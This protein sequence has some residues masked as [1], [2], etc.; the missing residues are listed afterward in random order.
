MHKISVSYKHCLNFFLM[1]P[2]H[3]HINKIQYSDKRGF[4]KLHV[5]NLDY[6]HDCDLDLD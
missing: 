5:L 3:R 2:D 1:E 4:L 6:I